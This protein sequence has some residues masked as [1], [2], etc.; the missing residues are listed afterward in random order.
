MP[1][2]D[3]RCEDGHVQEVFFPTFK[4]AE[5]EFGKGIPCDKCGKPT[6]RVIGQAPPVIYNAPGFYGNVPTDLAHKTGQI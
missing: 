1:R 4:T 5:D 6:V 2:W 3:I